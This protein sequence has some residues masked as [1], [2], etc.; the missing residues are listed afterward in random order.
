MLAYGQC[1]G[2]TSS[3]DSPW[4]VVPADDKNSSRLIVSQI[5]REALE[6]LQLSYPEAGL[7]RLRALK[8]IRAALE[9]CG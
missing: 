2:C 9:P 5:A 1:L 7:A 8:E 3:G 6:S 4:Y